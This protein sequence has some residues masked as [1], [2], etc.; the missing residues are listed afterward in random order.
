VKSYDERYFRRWYRSNS[1]IVTAAERSRRIEMVVA[2]AEYVLARSV[3]SVLDV[4]CGEAPWQ[5]V[6]SRLRN[7]ATYLGVDSSEYVVRRFGNRR[8]IVRGSFADI[9]TVVPEQAFD[10]VVVSDVIHYLSK[11]ELERGLG[12]LV[13]RVG[14]VA[15]L[16]FFTSRDAVEGD[17]RD[18]KLR[19]PKYY[20]RLFR[21]HGLHPLG[22]QLYAG[23]ETISNL[24]AMENV[25]A[26]L[27]SPR[28]RVQTAGS[29]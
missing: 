27:S 28:A 11:G 17:L 29:S 6:L 26:L 24:A 9:E 20:L 19:S 18:M 16:D 13:E 25:R 7:S 8:G 14:G 22:M 3:K 2:A 21:S 10:L 12:A 23:S 4:G 1:R 5:P 15:Y